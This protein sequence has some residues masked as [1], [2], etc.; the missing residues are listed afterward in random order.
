[1]LIRTR[2]RGAPASYNAQTVVNLHELFPAFQDF[3][4]LALICSQDFLSFC[5][6]HG[7]ASMK[8][9][10]FLWDSSASGTPPASPA[11]RTVGHGLTIW[12]NS[13]TRGL[14]LSC[15][16]WAGSA[17][18]GLVPCAVVWHDPRIAVPQMAFTFHATGLAIIID[19]AILI[20]NHIKALAKARSNLSKSSLRRYCRITPTHTQAS[21]R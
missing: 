13:D 10:S 21:K 15:G 18:A 11:R 14:A 16:L 3:M 17:K 9:G 2:I 12:T 5:H 7:T 6:H 1:M 4:H 19:C 8:L 20:Q